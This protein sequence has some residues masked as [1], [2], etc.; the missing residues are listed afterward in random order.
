MAREGGGKGR[1]R[2][3]EEEEEEEEE[4]RGEEKRHYQ[5]EKGRGTD[6]EGASRPPEHEALETRRHD[7]GDR[8][9]RVT[10]SG[11]E[12]SLYEESM[13]IQIGSHSIRLPSSNDLTRQ[14]AD[15]HEHGPADD[16]EHG[17]ANA[18]SPAEPFELVEHGRTGLHKHQQQEAAGQGR[19][20][21]MCL[22]GEAEEPPEAEA[23]SLVN[24][25]EAL[26]NEGL[27]L[28]KKLPPRIFHQVSAVSE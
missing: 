18:A 4:G 2:R 3:E 24:T 7:D 28:A 16:H 19:E 15:D 20:D 14:P 22:R 23:G 12:R 17:P 13:C 21:G 11:S 25:V 26:V 10:P 6:E 1:E 5:E 9:S 8:R 27:E